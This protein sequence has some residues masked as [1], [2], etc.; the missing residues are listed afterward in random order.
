MKNAFWFWLALGLSALSACNP[1]PHYAR[2]T[3]P[4]PPSYKEAPPSEYKEVA[5]WKIAEPSDDK[6][7]P[8]WWEM[9]ND[10]RLNEL[11]EHVQISNQNI[12]AAEANFRAARAVVVQA[13]SSL[14]PT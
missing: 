2:P 11:E 7:R 3:V 4:A 14:F 9:Y 8:N 6:I 5:G 12:A 1:A 13:R 10:P